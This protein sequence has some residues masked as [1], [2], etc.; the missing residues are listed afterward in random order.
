MLDPKVLPPYWT[1]HT[2]HFKA[3]NGELF[4]T[5]LNTKKKIGIQFFPGCIIWSKFIGSPLPGKDL[6]LGWDTYCQFDK[7]RIL[8]NGIRFKRDFKPFTTTLKIFSLTNNPQFFKEFKQTFLSYCADNHVMFKHPNPL[9]HNQDFF[10][11]LL[12][13]L[14]EDANPT[15]A[16]HPGMSPSDLQPARQECETLLQQGLI[17]PTTS[18]WACQVFYV[19][20]RSEKI[21]GKKRLVIDYKPLN[22]FLQDDKFPLPKTSTLL[23]HLA[24]AKLFSKFDLATRY[25]PFRSSQNRLLHS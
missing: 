10:I 21:R 13:K 20:K 18:P 14:N 19:E 16:S 6:L 9:W 24:K 8:P 23:V 5:K 22:R 7:L 4:N 2:Q 1:N 15:K 25:S 11:K 17:E 12:F 3:A